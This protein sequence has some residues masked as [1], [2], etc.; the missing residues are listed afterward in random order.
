MKTVRTLLSLSLFLAAT[1][2]FAQAQ[3]SHPTLQ[4]NVPFQFT[5]ADQTFPAGVYTL[6]TVQTEGTIL[7]SG[8]ESRISG[9]Q[10]VSPRHAISPSENSRLVFERYGSTYFLKEVWS[11]GSDMAR[12]LPQGKREREMAKAGVTP[13]VASVIAASSGR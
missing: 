12:T 9:I 8:K 6:S 5:V 4:V 10:Q 2:F 7:I 11:A 13:Q 1:Q 3:G